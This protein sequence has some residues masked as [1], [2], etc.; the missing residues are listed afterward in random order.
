MTFHTTHGTARRVLSMALAAALVALSAAPALAGGLPPVVAPIADQTVA[1]GSTLDIPVLAI[2]PEGDPLV[3]HLFG[4]PAFV[5]LA[6]NGNGTGVLHVAP[7]YSDAGPHS[8][9]VWATDPADPGDA[10]TFTITVTDNLA[11]TL[12]PIA[13]QNVNELH[14]FGTTIT[15]TDP[16]SDPLTFSKSAGPGWV[17]ISG[18]GLLEIS[19]PCGAALTSPYAVTAEVTDGHNPPA[20]ASFDVVVGVHA[21]VFAPLLD[22]TVAEGATATPVI[23][24][25]D[26]GCHSPLIFTVPGD[27]PPF[28]SLA[29]GAPGTADLTLAPGFTDEG[30]YPARVRA[31]Y[32]GSASE[33]LDFTIRVTHTDRQPTLAP[34]AAHTVAEN[35]TLDVAISASDPDGDTL[36]FFYGAVP[37]ASLGATITDNGDGTG[38]LHFAP[39]FAATAGSPY[40]ITVAVS[41][42]SGAPVEE[43]FQLTVTNTDKAPV[44]FGILDQTV[45]EGATLDVPI[46]ASDYDNDPLFFSYVGLLP[47]ALHATLTDNGDGTGT[48]HF[49]PDFTTASGGPY[50][51]TV[52]VGETNGVLT[53]QSIFQLT[54]T[55]TPEPV[56]TVPADM[57]REATSPAGAVVSFTATAT[58]DID[59]SITPACVPASG[60]TFALGSTTVICTATDSLGNTGT[61]TFHVTVQDTTAPVIEAAG[62]GALPDITVNATSGSGVPVTFAALGTD[63]VDG[64]TPVTCTPPSGSVFPIGVTQVTCTAT[65]AVGNVASVTFAVTVQPQ[66]TV[67]IP[68]TS[69]IDQQSDDGQGPSP[70]IVVW[71]LALAA[72]GGLF[73]GLSRQGTARRSHR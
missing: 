51:I 42:G 54:V 11:P 58:D 44:M 6:D 28:A 3:L 26:D 61:G 23:S 29:D 57:T 21:P 59:G 27:L 43:T 38:T 47:A 32:A 19:P 50:T 33:N 15:A 10:V 5:T 31:S 36:A 1:E 34:I 7:G 45:A 60:S 24:V 22:P 63:S 73:A 25:T 65:D 35:A 17:T 4:A 71:V 66:P 20:T 49:A 13:D 14:V 2:D 68:P 16:E 39:D 18:G 8:A 70:M 37:P 55:D 40:T 41:D 62:G 12:D 56:V 30:D 53:D 48:L 52:E 72:L 69:T 67:S 46:E 64:S 9:T